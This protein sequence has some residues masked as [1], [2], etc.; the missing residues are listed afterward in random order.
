MMFGGSDVGVSLILTVDSTVGS[1]RG[2]FL[3]RRASS[4]RPALALVGEPRQLTSVSISIV[5]GRRSSGQSS[6]LIS[7][8]GEPRAGWTPLN[9]DFGRLI[10]AR[11]RL[12]LVALGDLEE[13]QVGHEVLAVDV[14]LGGLSLLL[15][16][17]V[18]TP[19]VE[20]GRNVLTFIEGRSV[21]K[22]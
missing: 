9:R 13:L 15:E 1:M 4:S 11:R 16:V 5:D 17:C 2:S 20:D 7:L 6:P 10:S 18:L 14:G 3:P 19:M 21:D 22:S 12:T 8:P